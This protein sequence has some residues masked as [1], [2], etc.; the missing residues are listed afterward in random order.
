M[1]EPLA[2]TLLAGVAARLPLGRVTTA[3]AWAWALP[4]LLLGLLA[5]V[6]P[7]YLP[8]GAAARRSSPCF[9]VRWQSGAWRPGSP[10]RR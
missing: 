1:T 3:G 4:G 9:R 7:E 10:P 6:R 8:F 5:L 2:V